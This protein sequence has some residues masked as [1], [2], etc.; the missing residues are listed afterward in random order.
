MFDIF[1]PFKAKKKKS[2]NVKSDIE[3]IRYITIRGYTVGYF[4]KRSR[5]KTI[6]FSVKPNGLE[7]KAPLFTRLNYIENCIVQKFDW[8]YVHLKKIEERKAYCQNA[9]QE[10]I[11]PYLGHEI[12]FRVVPGQYESILKDN[13]LY[14]A[15]PKN[16]EVSEEGIRLALRKW[17]K[18]VAQ[19]YLTNLIRDRLMKVVFPRYP[20]TQFRLSSAYKS[21]LGSCTTKGVVSISWKTLFLEES[22][23]E[24]IVSHELAH[25]TEMNHSH[26]FWE[27]VSQYC[28]NWQYCEKQLKTKGIVLQFLD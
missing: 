3:P 6:S 21:R 20:F 11:I 5:R 24:Y 16:K 23:I 13:V 25:L 15:Y 8:I 19:I 26:R 9:L 22:L 17:Y 7:I 14:L 2:Q 10:R 18:S 12:T 27:L 4:L 1:K 28:P